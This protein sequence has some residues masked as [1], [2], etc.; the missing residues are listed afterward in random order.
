M[1]AYQQVL[2][3]A[4]LSLVYSTLAE[5]ADGQD[6]SHSIIEGFDGPPPSHMTPEL[7]DQ[8]SSPDAC[9]LMLDEIDN[10]L[11]SGDCPDSLVFHGINEGVKGYDLLHGD[12]YHD[13]YDPGYRSQIFKAYYRNEW[14]CLTPERGITVTSMKSCSS[15]ATAYAYDSYEG[16]IK[17]SQ[18]ASSSSKQF[19]LGLETT[20]KA[21]IPDTGISAEATIPPKFTMGSGDSESSY[22]MKSFFEAESGYSVTAYADCLLHKVKLSTWF[23]PPFHEL[24]SRAIQILDDATGKTQRHQR[25]SF[26]RFLNEF[27]THYV[28]E[29]E[30]GAK[31]SHTQ[32]YSA[33]TTEKIGR[34]TLQECATKS[35]SILWF[36]KSESS[37]CTASDEQSIQS[38]GGNEYSA[39]TT[40][41]GSAPPAKGEHWFDQE[42]VAS[43]LKFQLAPIVNLFTD[44]TIAD[45]N[46]LSFDKTPVDASQLRKVYAPLYYNYCGS[47]CL[48]FIRHCKTCSPNGDTCQTCEPGYGAHGGDCY[49]TIHIIRELTTDILTLVNPD[50]LVYT[51]SKMHNGH[52]GCASCAYF[53][54]ERQLYLAGGLND[55]NKTAVVHPD[56]SVS[57]HPVDIPRG[58]HRGFAQFSFIVNDRLY[59]AGLHWTKNDAVYSRSI[60]N[61]DDWQR[62][63]DLPY[64]FRFTARSAVVYQDTV[65][66]TGGWVK[67]TIPS[68]HFL[69]WSPNQKAWQQLPSMKYGR[70]N[71]CNVLVGDNIFVLGVTRSGVGRTV[72][73]YNIPRRMWSQRASSPDIRMCSCAAAGTDIYVHHDYYRSE[74]YRYNTV[75]DIWTTVYTDLSNRPGTAMFIVQ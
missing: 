4:V 65:Y 61:I 64:G 31:V 59:L 33:Y 51:S 38:N 34:E 1:N 17:Q 68:N 46:L 6:H 22:D 57:T 41:I 25:D 42:F 67:N 54:Y 37:S 21:E 18:A 35:K 55:G 5:Q 47:E 74:V 50:F 58:E 12:I 7:T 72:E 11:L 66:I 14:D 2:V 15:A 8:C 39:I 36:Y 53:Q 3:L 9:P 24:F 69:S 32:K 75:E 49:P 56:G 43:P 16:F 40:T 70:E 20:I 28:T 44:M 48:C 63:V 23:T 52:E 60:S 13:R 19:Q 26:L 30:F 29:T 27:G 45:Q 73:V 71:H 10:S 62:E